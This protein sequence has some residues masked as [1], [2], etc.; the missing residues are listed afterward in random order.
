M[1]GAPFFGFLPP[2]Q[3]RRSGL[4]GFVALGGALGQVRQNQLEQQDLEHF[5]NLQ[6]IAKLQGRTLGPEDFA[7]GFQSQKFR[8]MATDSAFQGIQQP[9]NPLQQAQADYYASR[10]KA[11]TSPK[12]SGFLFA[13]KGDATG[14]PSGTVYEKDPTG[15][16][17]I[18]HRPPT[19]KSPEEQLKFW[20][21]VE[22][23]A[24]GTDP[25]TSQNR[26]MANLM[27][28]DIPITQDVETVELARKKIAELRKQLGLPPAPKPKTAPIPPRSPAAK[29]AALS[30]PPPS[31][32]AGEKAKNDA[33]DN[34]I[35]NEVFPNEKRPRFETYQ[36]A[37]A[38]KEIWEELTDDEKVS[39]YQKIAIEG[40]SG[41][42][43]VAAFRNAG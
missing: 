8:N 33:V 11:Q 34:R 7:Q 40:W 9:L 2:P 5:G 3:Q 37:R 32:V 21:T 19:D 20:Q 41:A 23:T 28:Q 31:K 26:L 43:V 29:K 27:G 6:R 18:L 16:I 1:A 13:K 35:F 17:Q 38:L 22:R 24:Q 15:N 12:S 36:E 30:G 10:A 25:L 42:E 39:A 4:E 14:L